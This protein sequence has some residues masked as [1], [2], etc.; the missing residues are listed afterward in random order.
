MLG[1][2]HWGREH[3]EVR[4]RWPALVGWAPLGSLPRTVLSR[5]RC[6][7]RSK[8]LGL[9][10]PHCAAAGD[11]VLYY[12]FDTF[13][14]E[15]P[16]GLAI[17]AAITP[18][19]QSALQSP[20]SGSSPRTGLWVALCTVCL[21]RW[22]S[23][24]VHGSSYVFILPS[25]APCDLYCRPGAGVQPVPPDKETPASGLHDPPPLSA[26]RALRV[27]SLG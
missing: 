21:P 6:A 14:T 11:S 1:P 24:T 15:W 19:A 22:V 17:I 3:L 8:P 16:S 23:G 10:V 20:A 26:P 25:G 9:C 4:S 7:H 13:G 2:G 27:L 5:R 18:V 12:S